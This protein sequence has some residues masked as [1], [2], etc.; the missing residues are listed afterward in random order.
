M[1]ES[2]DHS[3][4]SVRWVVDFN[5]RA[6]R[7]VRRV[8]QELAEP[9]VLAG[10]VA[11]DTCL[12]RSTRH[13]SAAT[14]HDVLHLG[15]QV[16]VRWMCLLN[17]HHVRAK[18]TQQPIPRRRREVVRQLDDAD[19]RQRSLEPDRG[20]RWVRFEPR[21]R[22]AGRS[23]QPRRRRRA[24]PW[25]SVRSPATP[26]ASPRVRRRRSPPA[27]DHRP[28]ASC[29]HE[30]ADRRGT[31]CPVAE[32]EGRRPHAAKAARSRIRGL[33]V[34][35]RAAQAIQLGS[36]Q[37]VDDDVRRDCQRAQHLD[38]VIAMAIENDA[39]L[40]P[41]PRSLHMPTRRA[42]SAP[43]RSILTTSAPWSARNIVTIATAG[44][45]LRSRPEA[46]PA[47]SEERSTGIGGSARDI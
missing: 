46:H 16:V 26:T 31:P 7:Q 3:R 2:A 41:G 8:A 30:P 27:P 9:P 1:E 25:V 21:R 32:R 24:S 45:Q 11:R 15:A 23:E 29:R 44:L 38:V 10:D 4:P 14:E 42:G 19:A 40:A 5:G 37:T 12:R 43:G 33:Q 6:G 13:S 22:P 28:A 36:T 47:G 18:I 34:R 17:L 20:T 39:A 35:V